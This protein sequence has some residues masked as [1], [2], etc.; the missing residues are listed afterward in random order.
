MKK[1]WTVAIGVLIGLL[2]IG[3]VVTVR[4]AIAAGTS[5]NM[6]AARTAILAAQA[7]LDE[8]TRSHE[9]QITTLDTI[10]KMPLTGTERQLV[11][12]MTQSSTTQKAA[13]SAEASC[14][15]AIRDLWQQIGHEQ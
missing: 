5:K 8:A 2:M 3:Q 12:M 6:A 4:Y 13:L 10:S 1:H 7:A 14:L 9:A 11:A 15:K